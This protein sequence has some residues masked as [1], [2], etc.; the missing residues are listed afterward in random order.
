MDITAEQVF[1]IAASV[2]ATA[3]VIAAVFPTPTVSPVLIA[4]NKILNILAF[5][6]LH[7]KNAE[8]VK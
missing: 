6:F 1:N 7:A 5:N 3:S 4:A 8:D 2:V